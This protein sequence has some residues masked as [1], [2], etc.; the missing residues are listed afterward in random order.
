MKIFDTL[1]EILDDVKLE[2]GWGLS[3]RFIIANLILKDELREAVSFARH[4]IETAIKYMDISQ[5][6]AKKQLRKAY[7]DLSYLG[8]FKNT[9]LKE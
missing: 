4:D 1:K 9:E 2:R 8:E 5:D 3:W 6:F 7:K